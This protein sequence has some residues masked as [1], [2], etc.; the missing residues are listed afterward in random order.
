VVH[1][2]VSA[3]WAG[4]MAAVDRRRKLGVVG[5][6]AVGL[7]IAAV[8]LGLVARRYPAIRELPM[9][10]QVLDHVAFGAI[11]GGMTAHR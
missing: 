7:V 4:V 8:D 2:I 11:V 5:G 9:V 1:V 6:A 3:W 10:P